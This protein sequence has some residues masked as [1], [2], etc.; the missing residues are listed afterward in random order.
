MVRER[1][2]SARER[3]SQKRWGDADGDG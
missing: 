2:I 1:D 3:T